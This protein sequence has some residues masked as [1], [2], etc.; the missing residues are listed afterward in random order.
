MYIIDNVIYGIA[1][2]EYLLIIMTSG[3]TMKANGRMNKGM[4]NL[5]AEKA[6]LIK[7]AFAIPEATKLAGAVGGV[8]I[9]MEER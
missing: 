1:N 3:Y 8:I 6:V 7:L 2:M 4:P 5:I 9:A